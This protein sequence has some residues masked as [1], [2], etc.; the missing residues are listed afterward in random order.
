MGTIYK[1]VAHLVG[2]RTHTRTFPVRK[3]PDR[4]D[5]PQAKGT[6]RLRPHS[7]QKG[8]S[9]STFNAGETV[10]ETGIYEVLHDN[11]HR[12]A[13]E[14]VMLS[15]D[16][17][18]PCDTCETRVRFRLIRTAPYIFQDEDFEEPE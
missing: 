10:K 18:P 5:F 6:G 2:M 8:R 15:G 13:H 1:S 12:V 11:A 17:F 9:G 16:A 4:P 3:R 14:V 7:G